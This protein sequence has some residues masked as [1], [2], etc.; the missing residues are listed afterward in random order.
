MR[1]RTIV[2][3]VIAA[4]VLMFS[5]CAVGAAATSPPPTTAPVITAAPAPAP[6]PTSVIVPSGPQASFGNGQWAI[7][8]EVVPGTYRS[9]GPEEGV[10]KLCMIST[11]SPD[12]TPV[13]MQTSNDGPVRI[14]VKDGQTVDATGCQPFAK[15]K[16]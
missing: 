16:S 7:G 13:D 10:I 8:D 4:P 15:V 2:L 11:D 14:T 1:R 5:A 9:P 6:P 3:G 12:G